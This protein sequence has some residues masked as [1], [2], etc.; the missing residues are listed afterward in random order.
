MCAVLMRIYRRTQALRWR[1]PF[2]ILDTPLITELAFVSQWAFG[3]TCWEVFT[4]GRVPYVGV[5]IMTLLSQLHNGYRLE[6]PTNAT[7]SDE[8]LVE[9]NVCYYLYDVMR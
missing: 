2:K 6:R 5:P 7:C 3:V 4:C 9:C 1:K 8:M